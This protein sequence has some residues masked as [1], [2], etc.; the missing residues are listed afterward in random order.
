MP[1]RALAIYAHNALDG[2]WIPFHLFR[3]R[4]GKTLPREFKTAGGVLGYLLDLGLPVASIP[5]KKGE[6]CEIE[7]SG[8][9]QEF[10]VW[11]AYREER[12][13]IPMPVRKA[14]I[15]RDAILTNCWPVQT[16][17]RFSELWREMGDE[18]DQAAR[19]SGVVVSATPSVNLTPAMTFGN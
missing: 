17:K 2:R 10:R 19:W 14:P 18:A 5:M 7:V 16:P 11:A 6:A 4:N 3:F 1:K 15:I 12:R 13:M 9:Y 8:D